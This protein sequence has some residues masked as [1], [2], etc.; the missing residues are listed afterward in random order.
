M[1]LKTYICAC[2]A[3]GTIHEK[4]SY[5]LS[6][7]MSIQVEGASLPLVGCPECARIGERMNAEIGGKRNPDAPIAKAYDNGMTPETHAL[8]QRNWIARNS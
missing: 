4:Q 1:I 6:S 8:I 5:F 7:P 2:H 3:C